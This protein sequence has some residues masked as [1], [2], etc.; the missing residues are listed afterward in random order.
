MVVKTEMVACLV[1]AGMRHPDASGG[2]HLGVRGRLDAVFRALADLMQTG[3]ISARGGYSQRSSTSADGQGPVSNLNLSSNSGLGRV[4]ADAL[5]QLL[6]KAQSG[7]APNSCSSLA[8]AAAGGAG[9]VDVRD[10]PALLTVL[11][12]GLAHKE[13]VELAAWL[14]VGGHQQ[15]AQQGPGLQGMSLQE[16]EAAI[17]SLVEASECSTLCNNCECHCFSSTPLHVAY[18]GKDICTIFRCRHIQL[19]QP[20]GAGIKLSAVCL[21]S[22]RGRCAPGPGPGCQ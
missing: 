18:V 10:L 19:L 4:L 12:Q 14:R 20:A 15:Q 3:S 8:H 7:R 6:T 22:C 17:R 11:L 1:P 9:M 21:P 13:V 5:R 2:L 16:L